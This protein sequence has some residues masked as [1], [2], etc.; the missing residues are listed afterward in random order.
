MEMEITRIIIKGCQF[1]INDTEKLEKLRS[2]IQEYFDTK[3][4]TFVYDI[5]ENGTKKT[6]MET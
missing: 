3:D 1:K 5:K 2:D 6:K 4:V